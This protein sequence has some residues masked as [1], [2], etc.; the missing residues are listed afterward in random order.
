MKHAFHS[1]SIVGVALCILWMQY[2]SV[3]AQQV[4]SVTESSQRVGILQQ[5][6][7]LLERKYVLPDQATEYA[8]SFHGLWR[9]GVYDSILDP[10]EF[11][12]RVTADLRDITKDQHVLFRVVV[13]SD[14]GEKA[15]SALHHPV[16]YYRLRVREN[17]G[18]AKLEWLDGDIGFLELRRFNAF[19]EA[20]EMIIAA[21]RF[22][23]NASA[24][25]VDIRE[26]GG[27]SGDY[28]SSYFLRHP[29]QLTGWY[30]REDDYLTEFWTLREPGAERQ[31]EVPLFILTSKRTFSAAESFAYDMQV[32]KRAI[33]VGEPTRGG[34][35]SVDL[36]KVGSQFEIYIPTA[37]AVNPVTG[38]N[39]EGTGVL[40]DIV[41]P[42]TAALDTAI[43]LARKAGK[44][45]AS[46]K[47]ANLKLSVQEMERYMEGA[48]SFY[49][50]HQ[51]QAGHAALDSVFS[52]AKKTG[53]LTE[54]FVDVLAYNFTSREDEQIL[55]AILRKKIEHFPRSASAY[56][57]LAYAY[58]KNGDKERAIENY[59][60]VLTLEP[61]DRN[62]AS[63]IRRLQRE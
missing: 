57:T 5:I 48:E 1:C 32:R 34:A 4:T 53:L 55:Y 24:L 15:E 10:N 51:L 16:R 27:G 25:I 6:D 9:S 41:V 49:R 28:L 63:M 38:A 42:A 17:T 54:F 3:R 8:A 11:A 12:G 18:F 21:M 14:A 45:F 37:R 60:N 52:I 2:S 58:F 33:L 20:Q 26:N 7:S 29:T 13:S 44:A 47:E 50:K 46:L 30:S 23:S 56:E 40:P 19:S 31:T 59:R 61:G 39:W 62:A 36:F 43:V 35:H 22:L